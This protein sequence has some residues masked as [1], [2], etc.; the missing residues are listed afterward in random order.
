M[1]R[2]LDGAG[3]A[4]TAQGTNTSATQGPATALDPTVHLLPPT[5]DTLAKGHKGDGEY[6]AGKRKTGE[7]GAS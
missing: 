2:D 3:A 4:T 1:I 6:C 5:A 7:G